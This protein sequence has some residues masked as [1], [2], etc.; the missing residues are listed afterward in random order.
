MP[1][2]PSFGVEQVTH[3]QVGQLVEQL[4]VREPLGA[5]QDAVVGERLHGVDDHVAS[6]VEV[7]TSE[8]ASVRIE[9]TSFFLEV[10]SRDCLGEA[11]GSSRLGEY[12]HARALAGDARPAQLEY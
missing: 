9:L 10:S 4:V 5:G 7:R 11:S 8:L 3:D 1:R 12:L 6:E 2:R